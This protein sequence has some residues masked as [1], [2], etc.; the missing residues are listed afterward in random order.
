MSMLT[1]RPAWLT[2]LN[3]PRNEEILSAA[4]DVFAEKGIEGATMLEIATRAKVSKETL[5]ARFDSKEGLFY[6]LLAWGSRQSALDPEAWAPNWEA[7]PAAQLRSYAAA[8]LIKMMQ[9][10]SIDVQRMVIGAAGRQRDVAAVF[11]E[12]TCRA[13]AAIVG[14]LAE[15]L[16]A[17][18]DVEIDD[19]V[20]FGNDFIG[21]LRGNIHNDALLGVGARLSEAALTAHAHRAMDRLLKAYAPTPRL[22]AAA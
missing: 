5:Y 1:D 11:D 12:V 14:K 17:H 16:A 2:P 21:L 19:P 13:S 9:P 18:G 4:F 15:A 6:A 8:C 22:R 20:A 3:D 7:D 10:E